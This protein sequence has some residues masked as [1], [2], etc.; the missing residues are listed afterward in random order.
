MRV[1]VDVRNTGARDGAEV[2]QLYVRDVVASVSSP[3]KELKGF[4]RVN[5]RAGETRRVE[6]ILKAKDLGF[7]NQQSRYVV[8]DGD[9]AV[10][11]A[12]SS[13]DEGL[14]VTFTVEDNAE[15]SSSF[16]LVARA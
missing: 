15:T 4:E 16:V 7:H 6:M 14:K 3:V 12:T 5:L 8:E 2:V 11:V 13:A 9:F 1:S 10:T